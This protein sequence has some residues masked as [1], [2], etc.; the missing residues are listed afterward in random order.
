MTGELFTLSRKKCL[1]RTKKY[2][3]I[4]RSS[5]LSP[6]TL[7]LHFIE[8][9]SCKNDDRCIHEALGGR[10]FKKEETSLKGYRLQ[11]KTSYVSNACK[12]RVPK[13]KG[14]LELS[15]WIQHVRPFWLTIADVK[16]LKPGDKLEIVYLDRNIYDYLDPLPKNKMLRP[17]MSFQHATGMYVHGKDMAGTLILDHKSDDPITVEPFE[18]DV[19]Y[20]KGKWYPLYKGY[21]PARDDQ[22]SVDL[23]G[24]KTHWTKMPPTTA[25]G[26]RGP[27][28]L[29]SDL[30]E[31]PKFYLYEEYQ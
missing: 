24:K 8:G 19:E 9:V 21:L 14:K 30:N 27:M 5:P 25:V 4:Q 29:V 26:S 18:F 13:K 6:T 11:K 20:K 23:L 28:V 16:R 3:S 12:E 22:T 31:L 17:D 15:E 7:T 1:R 10:R 2:K